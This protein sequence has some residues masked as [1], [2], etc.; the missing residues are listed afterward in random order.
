MNAHNNNEA[1]YL[2]LEIRLQICLK[3]GVQRLCIRGDALLV[4]KQVLSVWKSKNPTLK[5]MCYRIKGLLKKFKAWSIRHVPRAQNE[6]A[7]E[8]AQIK[9]GELFVVK[10]DVP[11]YLGR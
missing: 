9:I 3:H 11:L 1:E 2:T 6:E 7:H 10:A 4:V 5:D 8:V